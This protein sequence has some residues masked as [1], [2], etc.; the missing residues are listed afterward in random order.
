M[1][2]RIEK[3]G[4]TLIELLVV[5]GIIG[6]LSAALFPFF[7]KIRES[8]HATEC[9]NN[10][11]AFGRAAN[12]YMTANGMSFPSAG[13]RVW[14]GRTR[15]NDVLE[16]LSCQLRGWVYFDH[17]CLREENPEES[18]TCHDDGAVGVPLW[19][20]LEG[21]KPAPWYYAADKDQKKNKA[22]LAIENGSLFGYMKSTD[23]YRCKSF[24]K[25]AVSKFP[26]AVETPAAVVRSYAMNYR[27][28]ATKSKDLYKVR[29]EYGDYN[30]G[31]KLSNTSAFPGPP[32]KTALMV[33]LDLE[34]PRLGVENGVAG[35]QV[36]DWDPDGNNQENVGFCHKAGGKAVGHICFLDGHVE[37]VNDPG[38]E[39]DRRKYSVWLGSGGENPEGVNYG[40]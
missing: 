28:S 40:E 5:I 19:G 8:A 15:V 32:N 2:K 20:G 21:V 18:C 16:P 31:S 37:T 12:T 3:Q 26:Q 7:G 23:R 38:T 36:W 24:A 13:G 9:R 34:N 33:E 1:K 39:E 35:D 25:E 27:T 10:L 11:I 14:T 4:F 22:R 29:N 17:N 30:N 6:I